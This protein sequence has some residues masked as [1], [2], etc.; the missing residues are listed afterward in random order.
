M[1]PIDAVNQIEAMSGSVDPAQRDE[2][3]LWLKGR[4]L[5]SVVNSNGW[6]VVLEILQGYASQE[7]DRLMNTDPGEKDKVFAAHAVAYAASRIYKLFV[8]D[9]NNCIRASINTPEVVRKTFQQAS[10]VPPESL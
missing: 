6:D 2:V 9:V 1:Q 8:E 10:P 4:A 5:A 7:V 3:E